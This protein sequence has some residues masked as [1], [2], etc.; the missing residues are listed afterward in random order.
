[1][2][3]AMMMTETPLTHELGAQRDLNLATARKWVVVSASA[4]NALGGPTGYAILPEESSVPYLLPSSPVRLKG[5]FVD[6]HLWV[7]RYAED[8][9]YAAGR[10]P[11]QGEPGQ[12]LVSSDAV[13]RMVLADDVAGDA[14]RLGRAAFSIEVQVVVHRI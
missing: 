1:M 14:Q 10:Y 8:E 6:H 12:G 13:V 4:K 2:S 7:T 11:N 5:R 3:N 9:M